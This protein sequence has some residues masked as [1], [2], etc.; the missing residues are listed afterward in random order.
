MCAECVFVYTQQ[1]S[2]GL[3]CS[4]EGWLALVCEVQR[5]G[6]LE[7]GFGVVWFEVL[8]GEADPVLLSTSA[9]T[10]TEHSDGDGVMSTL[11]VSLPLKE[12][13]HRLFCQIQLDDGTL[14]QHSQSLVL[15]NPSPSLEPCGPSSLVN[16]THVCVTSHMAVAEDQVMM[17]TTAADP[18]MMP[19]VFYAVVVVIIVFV[20][21]IVTLSIIVVY[22]YRRKCG[23]SEL[24]SP[25]GKCLLLISL[26]MKLTYLNCPEYRV[27]PFLDCTLEPIH[28]DELILEG[29]LEGVLVDDEVFVL[30]LVAVL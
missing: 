20:L 9:D 6:Q 24:S 22:L 1:P 11:T 29:V 13:L 10:H 21:I 17:V 12:E 26:L 5:H 4:P 18:E 28:F 3:T 25:I 2:S 30:Q 14:L 7:Q 16:T 8:R 15:T 27:V 19:V 23:H